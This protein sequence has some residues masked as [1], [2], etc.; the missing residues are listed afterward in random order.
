MQDYLENAVREDM[1]VNMD[2]REVLLDRPS[3]APEV[4]S[5]SSHNGVEIL[6]GLQ[7]HSAW[8]HWHIMREIFDAQDFWL[9]FM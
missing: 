1:L 6:Q 4:L 2:K 5:T 8:Q 3:V 7:R 9:A